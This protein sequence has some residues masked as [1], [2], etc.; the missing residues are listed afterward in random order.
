MATQA[1]RTQSR[2]DKL[3]DA[4]DI[5]TLRFA[6]VDAKQDLHESNDKGRHDLVQAS[7]AEV[8][9]A[10]EAMDSKMFKLIMLLVVAL[11]GTKAI[12]LGTVPI[13]DALAHERVPETARGQSPLDYTPGQSEN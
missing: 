10:V 9:K 2:V 3:E 11:A 8:K 12:E 6:Q 1:D 7:I 4:G 13:K 5:V